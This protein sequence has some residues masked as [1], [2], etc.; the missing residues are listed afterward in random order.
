M[1]RI[2]ILICSALAIN[3]ATA[4]EVKAPALV[5]I[6]VPFGPGGSND[7]IAR[8]IASPLAKR[9]ETNVIVDNKAGAS[10]V[11]G[12]D[13]VAKAPKDGSVLLL[14]SSTFLTV[15]ATQAKLPY[16]PLADFTPI[17]L[18]GEG[19][20][21][22]AVSAAFPV[23]TPAEY[24]AAARAKP[25]ELTYG[26]AGIGSIGHLAT[27]LLN[28]AAKIRMTHVAYKGAAPAIVDLAGGQIYAMISNYSSLLPQLTT[29]RVR[30][31]GITSKQT[32]PVF[33]N[34][35]PLS[36]TVP[37]YSMEI[38]V[39]VFAPAGTPAAIVERLNREIREISASPELRAFL[40][41]DG[42]L[43]VPITSAALGVLLKDELAQWK[44]IAA[45]RK[46]VTE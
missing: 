34:L 3:A 2:A 41:P 1:A 30:A 17:A 35:P 43:P 31:L 26:S 27:E 23:K 42:A 12:N 28:S 11:I 24:I 6:I 22:L 7:V 13:A 40:E 5:R 29:R 25:G 20:M 39:C 36:A 32:S 19:P 37:G 14:T 44:A 21:L 15:A 4:A 16:D 46:I 18:V 45:E 8:A 33:A 10:G 9:L 38:W